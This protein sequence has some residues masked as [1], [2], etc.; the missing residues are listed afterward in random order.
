MNKEVNYWQLPGLLAVANESLLDKCSEL[1]SN[2]YGEWGQAGLFPGKRIKLSRDRIRAWLNCK[3]STL[4]CAQIDDDIIGYAIAF[5]KNVTR[6]YGIITW[7]TQ[8]VVH[9]DYRHNGIAKNILFSIWGLSTHYAWGIVSAN[10]YAVRALEKATR[11][12]AI[13]LRIKKNSVKLLNLGREYVPFVDNETMVKVNKEI[14]AINT[15]FFVEHNTIPQMLENVT[16]VEVPWNLGVVEEGWEWFAFTFQDQAPIALTKE[17]IENMI[18]TSDNVVKQA[19][20]RMNLAEHTWTKKTLSE[21]DYIIEKTGLSRGSFVYDLGCGIGRHAITLAEKGFEVVGIDYLDVNVRA[22]KEKINRMKLANI[23]IQEADCRYYTNGRKSDLVICLYDVVGTYSNEEDNAKILK[24]A[25]SLLKDG[26]IAVFS[27][28]NF[29]STLERA[30]HKFSLE[31]DANIL[32]NLPASKTMEKTGD[33]FNPEYY[34]VDTDTHLVY[35]REQF[36]EGRSL[37]AELIVRDKR[38]TMLEIQGLCESVGFEVLEK[39]YTNASDW[40]V[41]HAATSEKAKEILLICKKIA[42][43]QRF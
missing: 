25:Y 40:R 22:A 9:T 13:P 5:S 12:R 39:K 7:V 18:R 3:Y 41:S 30:I 15:K 37:P 36:T 38:Y 21:V 43:D 31:K 2:H 6:G 20:S 28:M 19:Y 10:P 29:E 17:E 1:Y 26:G 11:R 27:V 32:V 34:A 14:S 42:S 8:L 35:R 33:V 16:S 23:D 24:T 4:Y